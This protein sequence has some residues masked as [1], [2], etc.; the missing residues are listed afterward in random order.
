MGSACLYLAIPFSALGIL[1][2][3]LSR[4]KNHQMHGRARIG[5]GISI[6]GLV[7]SLI[8]TVYVFM[9]YLPYIQ[10]GQFQQ[11]LEEYMDRYYGGDDFYSIP[12]DG[13]SGYGSGTLDDWLEE[14]GDDFGWYGGGGS[15]SPY[16]GGGSY[17][18][19]TYGTL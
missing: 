7:I 10:S 8:L 19:D 17:S 16:D 2:A 6:A 9:T 12:D 4:D 1:F 13:S 5:L 18:G 11:Y 14:F 3:I 15:Y